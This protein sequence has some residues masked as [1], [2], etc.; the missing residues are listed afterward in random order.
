LG[1][2]TVEGAPSAGQFD[3]CRLFGTA[4]HPTALRVENS[5]EVVLSRCLLKGADAQAVPRSGLQP[6]GHGIEAI[7]SFVIVVDSDAQGG[8]GTVAAGVA[9]HPGGHGVLLKANSKVLMGGG[10]M[11]GGAAGGT[12]DP[13]NLGTAGSGLVL[14]DSSA[15][16]RGFGANDDN[17]FPAPPA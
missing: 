7:A 11:N 1:G 16:L 9:P 12:M 4:A 15:D 2:V 17:V 14:Q 8:A 13:C 10:S 5:T 6:S 3:N